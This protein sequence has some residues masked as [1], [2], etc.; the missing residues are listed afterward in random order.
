MLFLTGSDVSFLRYRCLI[1]DISL[2]M[3]GEHFIANVVRN[4]S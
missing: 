4:L 1:S 2:P 3:S